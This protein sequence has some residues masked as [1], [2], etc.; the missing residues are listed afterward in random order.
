VSFKSVVNAAVV[1]PYQ[2]TKEFIKKIPADVKKDLIV[3]SALVGGMAVISSCTESSTTST[4]VEREVRKTDTVVVK[5]TIHSD[6]VFNNKFANRCAALNDGASYFVVDS[7][8]SYTLSDGTKLETAFVDTLNSTQAIGAIRATLPNG[9]K[10]LFLN[11]RKDST[12]SLNGKNYTVFDFEVTR[13][14][15]AKFGVIDS[16]A[17]LVKST[18]SPV[19]NSHIFQDHNSLVEGNNL[20]NVEV[21]TKSGTPGKPSNTAYDF[22]LNDLKMFAGW[23]GGRDLIRGKNGPYKVNLSQVLGDDYG[24][25]GDSRLGARQVSV[26]QV[27]S[28]AKIAITLQY[29]NSSGSGYVGQPITFELPIGKQSTKKTIQVRNDGTTIE[30]EFSNALFKHE[31]KEGVPQ[32]PFVNVTGRDLNGDIVF[33]TTLTDKRSTQAGEIGGT[34]KVQKI[35]VK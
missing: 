28:S 32:V 9:K 16:M 31:A 4:L 8:G 2:K 3:G 18:L 17:L 19:A 26:V 30:L 23:C 21:T 24:T 10:E 11:L 7:T 27:P 13:N 5:D 6:S 22:L 33:R 35:E 1:A 15:Y 25:S 14:G 20:L 34:L 29:D 12:F